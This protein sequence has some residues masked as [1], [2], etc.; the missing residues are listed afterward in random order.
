MDVDHAA[1]IAF[2]KLEK[3]KAEFFGSHPDE[4]I[5]LH[6][7]DIIAKRYPF[8]ALRDPSKEALFSRKFIGLL[9]SLDYTIITAVIDKLEHLNRYVVWRHDPY[10]YCLEILLER[11][12][13]WLRRKGAKG[14]V[15]GEVRGGKPDRRL[16]KCYKRIYENGTS[17][18]N[19]RQFQTHLTSGKLKLK[20]KSQNISGLQIADAIANPSAQHI[21]HQRKAAPPPDRFGAQIVELLVDSKYNRDRWTGAIDGIGTK[22]LP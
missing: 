7:K 17:F 9:E 11:Y 22:W 20:P 18:V 10:H 16:E 14:D 3:L 1:Q 4:P 15:M 12:V 13:I 21:R 8:D 19:A 5:I 2:P 6:R